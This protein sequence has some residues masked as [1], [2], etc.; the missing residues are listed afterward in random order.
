[1]NPGLVWLLARGPVGRV[2]YLRRHVRGVKRVLLATGLLAYLL[3]ILGTMIATSVSGAFAERAE[4]LSGPIREIAPPALLLIALLG[5]SSGT[6]LHFRPAEIDFLFPAPLSRRE[7]LLYNVISRLVHV[8]FL[9]VWAP[10]ALMMYGHRWYAVFAGTFLGLAFVQLTAQ[11]A[12]LVL[13]TAGERLSRQL[14]LLARVV[15]TLATLAVL[16]FAAPRLSAGAGVIE[17]AREVLASPAARVITLPAIPF[18]ECF[19]ARDLPTFAAW[20]LGCIAIL[21]ALVALMML[22]DAAYLEAVLASSRTVHE[23]LR[24]LRS[25]GAAPARRRRSPSRLPPALPWF[26]G[27]GP[28]AWRQAVEVRRNARGLVTLV[29][30]VV[31]MIV[32]THLLASRADPRRGLGTVVALSIVLTT[33]LTHLVAYDFRRDLERMAFLKSLPLSPLAAAAGQL[34]APTILFSAVQLAMV[35]TAI[36]VIGHIPPPPVVWLV[37][38]LPLVN[39]IVAATDNV[40]FLLYPY[41]LATDDPGNLGF[42]GRLMVA[43]FLKLLCLLAVGGV[44][45]LLFALVWHVTGGSIPAG[46]LALAALLLAASVV[47]TRLVARAFEAFDVTRDVPG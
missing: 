10:I 27:A 24:R 42:M 41:R 4:R 26:A 34:V 6:G 23:T 2:R 12:S 8:A 40:I 38:L 28:I 29:A 17:A 15:V 43:M 13:A 39:W 30:S 33:I 11:G 35:A 21:G 22:L 31:V 3:V 44:A 7:L 32:V 14:R 9:S 18:V 5:V 25:G 47:A 16:A 45:A 46:G 1:M 36:G 19:V 20:T 37:A